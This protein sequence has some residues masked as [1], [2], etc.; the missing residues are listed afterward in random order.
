MK[1][2][3]PNSC[4]GTCLPTCFRD[5]AVPP[6]DAFADSKDQKVFG[7][8]RALR[9]HSDT[10]DE[11]IEK[12]CCLAAGHSSLIIFLARPTPNHNV[13][14]LVQVRNQTAPLK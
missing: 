9:I 3:L 2:A 1:L 8:L 5:L 10:P 13:V 6:P 12:A 14:I 11:Q 7:A 4:L